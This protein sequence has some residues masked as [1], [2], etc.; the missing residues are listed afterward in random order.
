MG[1]VEFLRI[2][3]DTAPEHHRGIIIVVVVGTSAAKHLQRSGQQRYCQ[4]QEKDA[5]RI[6]EELHNAVFNPIHIFYH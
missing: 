2:G 5:A 1:T 6:R 3:R 4:S